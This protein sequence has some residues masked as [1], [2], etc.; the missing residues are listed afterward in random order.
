MSMFRTRID[1]TRGK[2]QRAGRVL[3]ADAALAI[4]D[5]DE[6]IIVSSTTGTKAVTFNWTEQTPTTGGC[7]FSIYCAARSGGSYTVACTYGGSAGTVTIDAQHEHP[8]FHRIDETV[9]CLDL[10]GSTFA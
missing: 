1:L 8:K 4:T 3:A 7:K 9:Y 10:G 5:T 2:V 6:T